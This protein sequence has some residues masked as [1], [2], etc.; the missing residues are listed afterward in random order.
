M[1]IRR[2]LDTKSFASLVGATGNSAGAILRAGK[3]FLVTGLLVGAGRLGCTSGA[4][5]DDVALVDGILLV[6]LF[7]EN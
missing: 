5:I 4:L 1:G 2:V 7:V 3:T 6:G